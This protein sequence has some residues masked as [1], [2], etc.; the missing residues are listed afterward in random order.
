MKQSEIAYM[1][2]VNW[3][4]SIIDK[5]SKLPMRLDPS[6]RIKSI[7]KVLTEAIEKLE[8]TVHPN[9]TIDRATQTRLTE[10]SEQMAEKDSESLKRK[11]EGESRR[12]FIKFFSFSESPSDFF[13]KR[14]QAVIA[15][16]EKMGIEYITE[17]KPKAEP[18]KNGPEVKKRSAP[19]PP[20][21][22]TPSVT[23][24]TTPSPS[25]TRSGSVSST[26][27]D[28]SRTSVSIDS[29]SALSSR[30]GSISSVDSEKRS[31]GSRIPPSVRKA[32]KTSDTP[33]ASGGVITDEAWDKAVAEESK[34]VAALGEKVIAS[35]QS[36]TSDEFRKK[37]DMLV[38]NL[39]SNQHV[40]EAVKIDRHREREL[41]S[42]EA[43][44]DDK[45][46]R[47]REEMAS[48]ATVSS[49][50]APTGTPIKP[51]SKTPPPRSM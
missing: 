35:S 44:R 32:A 19:K 23:K 43:A 42:K 28:G 45:A 47:A 18:I 4:N 37:R 7:N 10:I 20:S 41:G 15:Q 2:R 12:N 3:Y 48:R 24:L 14:H 1:R 6:N 34:R 5:I 40:S 50:S 29:S 8:K 51:P 38:R 30:T 25:S 9:Y 11:G 17:P 46:R 21:S 39:Y 49:I 27:S 22:K 13:D 16:Q 33:R 31:T 36:G 26:V